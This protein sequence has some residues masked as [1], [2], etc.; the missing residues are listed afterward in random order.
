MKPAS[1][2]WNV[3]DRMNSPMPR[4]SRYALLIVLTTMVACASREAL[5]PMANSSV[6]P[7]GVD[8]SGTWLIRGDESDGQRSINRAVSK[9]GGKNSRSSSKRKSD[10]GR[11]QVF[12]ETGSLLKITQTQDGFFVSLD[13]SVVEEFRFGENR[14]ISVGEIEAQRVSGWD[15]PVYMVQ[16]L[17]ENGM[18][19]IDRFWLNDNKD[20]LLREIT[21]RGRNDEEATVMQ[22]FDRQ[23][24]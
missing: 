13:R 23:A 4:L 21:F 15:G 8:F 24:R 7:D 20:V 22:Y 14:M 12:L 11:V 1:R 18:K 2:S 16:T 17:D 6:A 3:L 10:T 5:P 9:V 19:M